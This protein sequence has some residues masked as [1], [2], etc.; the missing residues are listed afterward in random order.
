MI[1]ETIYLIL[2]GFVIL[3][4]LT[5]LN[6]WSILVQLQEHILLVVDGNFQGLE[7]IS[8]YWEAYRSFAQSCIATLA[9]ACVGQRTLFTAR[10]SGLSVAL[11]V[12]SSV[13]PPEYLDLSSTYCSF[14]Q[15]QLNILFQAHLTS[16][17]MST[18]APN[19][20]MAIF[21]KEDALAITAI[22]HQIIANASVL[23]PKVVKGKRNSLFR[24]GHAS[25]DVL[26]EIAIIT[27]NDGTEA[28][29]RIKSA[30]KYQAIL[31][32]GLIQKTSTAATGDIA[33]S[34]YA[35]L[36]S[37]FLVTANELDV[38]K[39]Q[40]LAFEEIHENNATPSAGGVVDKSLFEKTK[41]AAKFKK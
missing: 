28:Q 33:P 20:G 2:T 10:W 34:V 21:P 18:S 31:T 32:H 16:T 38:R 36:E 41:V 39:G 23:F 27:V 9:Y 30:P 8:E 15:D 4:E 17:I 14:G 26:F 24:W 19:N 5:L 37:L 12:L 6:V 13:L 29:A 3:I 7:S 1:L 35:A 40:K 22:R 11:I 25:P